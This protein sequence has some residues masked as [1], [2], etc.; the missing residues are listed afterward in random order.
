MVSLSFLRPQERVCGE[1]NALDSEHL[2]SLYNNFK[3]LQRIVNMCL[4]TFFQPFLILIEN[5]LNNLFM[6]FQSGII[7]FDGCLRKI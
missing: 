5:C 2:I 3:C 6:F 7:F 4:Q 1:K